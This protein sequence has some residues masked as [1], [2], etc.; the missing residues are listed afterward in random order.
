MLDS[1]KNVQFFVFVNQGGGRELSFGRID[2][3]APSAL[4]LYDGSLAITI[5][6]GY[7]STTTIIA[8][9]G[10][11]FDTASAAKA[12]WIKPLQYSIVLLDSV[13]NVYAQLVV[14]Y[15]MA[16]NLTLGRIDERAASVLDT[17]RQRKT[18]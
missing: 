1:A 10:F 17:L 11:R 15:G 16:D 7:L 12:S 2:E 9:L 4:D 8:Q 3:N 13:Q 6:K 18:P 5:A 14:E